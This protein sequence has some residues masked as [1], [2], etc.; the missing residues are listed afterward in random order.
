[1]LRRKG[2]AVMVG[3]V[4]GFE[5]ELC[6]IEVNGRIMDVP[7]SRVGNGVRPGDVVELKDGIWLV[8][9]QKTEARG[10]EIKKLMDEVWED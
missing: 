8:N 2:D 9:R 4:E 6:R 1:M 3:I 10:K 5:G 7:R